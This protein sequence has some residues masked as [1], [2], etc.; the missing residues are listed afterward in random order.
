VESLSDET[1]LRE[2]Q[3]LSLA[4]E[5]SEFGAV[6]DWRTE[7]RD[8]LMALGL[9]ERAANGRL[10]LLASW[11][12][13]FEVGPDIGMSRRTWFRYVHDLQAAL[14]VDLRQSPN[15]VSLGVRAQQQARPVQARYA[16]ADDVRRLYAGL[17]EVA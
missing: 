14:G 9:S 8:R 4:G 11:M 5:V 1:M 12:A 7:G 3:K 15:V 2:Y 13:G 6:N 10:G 17:R 16:T